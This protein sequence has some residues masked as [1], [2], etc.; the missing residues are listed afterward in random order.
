[1]K[2]A[3]AILLTIAVPDVDAPVSL[4]P[5]TKSNDIG[6]CVHAAVLRAVFLGRGV[7][8]IR[9]IIRHSVRIV[10]N[11]QRIRVQPAVSR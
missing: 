2:K 6:H 7:H 4:L 10:V 11:G 9:S 3:L 5:K 8:L 1:M